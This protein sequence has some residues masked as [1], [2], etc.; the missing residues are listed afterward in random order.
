[1][2][3]DGHFI[4]FINVEVHSCGDPTASAYSYG[5]YWGGSDSLFDQIKLH[6]TTGYGFH[7]YSEGCEGDDR[8]PERNTIRN[9]E[10]YNTGTASLWPE[11]CLLSVTET[12]RMAI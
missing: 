4:E 2:Q 5:F 11:F 6:D 7:L 9:S 8:C 10:I 1:M 12:K 3:G